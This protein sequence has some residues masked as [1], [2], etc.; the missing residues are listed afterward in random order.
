MTSST[1]G[2]KEVTVIVPCYNDGATLAETAQSVI[3]GGAS[4]L[5]VDDGSTD[6][7][8]VKVLKNLE[9]QGLKV[10][11]HDANRGTAAALSTGLEKA[12]TRY[13]MPLGA[14]DLLCSGALEKMVAVL[15]QEGEMAVF[16]DYEYFGAYTGYHQT[17]RYWDPWLLTWLNQVPGVAVI[18]RD[19]ALAIGG[20]TYPGPHQDWDFWMSF[21]EAEMRALHVPVLLFRYRIQ[22]GRQHQT[23]EARFESIYRDLCARHPRLMASRRLLWRHSPSPWRVRLLVPLAVRVPVSARKRAGLAY[24][25]V[26]WSAGRPLRLLLSRVLAEMRA[27]TAS[28]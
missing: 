14:D 21:A 7:H 26:G 20:W 2:V 16:A 5:I 10:V 12:S 3:Q 22:V 4:L 23:S 6:G 8:T 15:D 9:E 24:V 11:R 1:V 28:K 13:I 19:A 18:R 27:K 25:I 17:L